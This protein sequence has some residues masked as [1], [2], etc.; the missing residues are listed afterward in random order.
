MDGELE[1]NKVYKWQSATGAYPSMVDPETGETVYVKGNVIL[2]NNSG[3]MFAFHKAV[4]DIVRGADVKVI[5]LK[6]LTMLVGQ[7][8]SDV[9]DSLNVTKS[10]HVKIRK[11]LEHFGIS[12][13]EW[14]V[15]ILVDNR[16][17]RECETYEEVVDKLNGILHELAQPYEGSYMGYG[18][19]IHECSNVVAALYGYDVSILVKRIM[20]SGDNT[21]ITLS[22]SEGLPTIFVGGVEC[23]SYINSL[24][25]FIEG[26]KASSF[27]N[28]VNAMS[29]D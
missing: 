4:I 17:I 10:A 20:E 7:S 11:A 24:R 23:K 29:G 28:A 21:M 22:E 3:K 27:E 6:P 2:K 26:D 19:Y 8:T 9:V 12:A 14:R 1:L 18:G 15:G 5:S 16:G 13:D 25:S